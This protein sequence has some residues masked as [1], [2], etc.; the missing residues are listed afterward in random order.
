MRIT[1]NMTANSSIYN[2]QQGRA[3]LDK[4]QEPIAT[5][6]NINRPSDDPIGTSLLLSIGD[7]IKAGDQYAS[8]ITKASTFLQVSSTAL[9][10]MADTMDLAK[11]LVATVSSGNN[12][13]NEISSAISQ[14]KTLKLQMVDMGNTQMGDQYVFGGGNGQKP[15]NPNA[16]AA[17]YYAGDETVL[18][19]EIG[20]SS[21]QQMNIPGNQLLTGS[22]AILP[23]NPTKNTPYGQTNI[24]QTFDDLIAA[25]GGNIVANI[26]AGAKSLEAGADQITKAQ[27]NAASWMMRLD[28]TTKMNTNSKNTLEMIV[29]NT[30]NVDYAKLAVQVNQQKIAFEA[31]LS[32]TAK[33]SQLS[34]LDFLR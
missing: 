24:L 16:V 12:T 22:S 26:Q 30:Q 6:A 2:L 5:E 20:Q 25:V 8:N 1:Q 19:V 7:Q 18:N 31:S 9:Q 32:A 10:G 28:S 15:F 17:P 4:L 3:K 14:L 11:K 21:A 27:T 23:A 33:L 13:P 34:L 29:G